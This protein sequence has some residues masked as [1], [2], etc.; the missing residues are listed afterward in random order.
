MKFKVT[1]LVPVHTVTLGPSY[2]HLYTQFHVNTHTCFRDIQEKWFLFWKKGQ[3]K[4]KLWNISTL[5]LE[6]YRKN[7]FRWDSIKQD[8]HTYISSPPP[9][10]TLFGRFKC[11]TFII[12]F[13]MLVSFG[14]NFTQTKPRGCLPL[15]VS[16]NLSNPSGAKTTASH[17]YIQSDFSMHRYAGLSWPL[18]DT[19]FNKIRFIL[20]H[21]S[22]W[23]QFF[24]LTR[25][26]PFL[27]KAFTFS[28]DKVKTWMIEWFNKS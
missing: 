25:A 6:I 23:S 5:Y 26:W 10:K 8:S 7:N 17:I 12:R 11:S 19:S 20:I 13:I 16:R 1:E 27:N 4:S 9:Q 28:G 3:N 24:K 21:T 2:D 22:A 18:N 15:Q 14:M